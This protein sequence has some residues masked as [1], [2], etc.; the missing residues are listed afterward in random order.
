MYDHPDWLVSGSVTPDG[1]TDGNT[2]HVY[3]ILAVRL[4]LGDRSGLSARPCCALYGFMDGCKNSITKFIGN[5]LSNSNEL[6]NTG[7]I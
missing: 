1:Y 7:L 5:A 4:R 6:Q 2:E 3:V